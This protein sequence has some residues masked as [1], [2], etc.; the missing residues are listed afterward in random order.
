M[1][2]FKK[3]LANISL[4]AV[5][6]NIISPAFAW[7]IPYT[8]DDNNTSNIFAFSGSSTPN[9]LN[10]SNLDLS[11]SNT[12][13]LRWRWNWNGW[14]IDTWEKWNDK[15]EINSNEAI[16]FNVWTWTTTAWFNIKHDKDNKHN[17][18]NFQFKAFAS[19]FA[20]VNITTSFDS[21]DQAKTK[22]IV[23]SAS[24]FQY[25][26][27][28][29]STDWLN[30]LSDS[31][32]TTWCAWWSTVTS[33]TKKWF[34]LSTYMSWT[35]LNFSQTSLPF[36]WSQNNPIDW[37]IQT[38]AWDKSKV[39]PNEV[40]ALDFGSTTVKSNVYIKDLDSKWTAIWVNVKVFDENLNEITWVTKTITTSTN[41]TAWSLKIDITA[42]QAFRYVT[43][44]PVDSV[45]RFSVYDT[46]DVYDFSCWKMTN[47]FRLQNQNWPLNEP[48]DQVKYF[49]EIWNP[50]NVD[51]T[52]INVTAEIP[53]Q[54]TTLWNIT[55]PAWATN[56][57]DTNTL[58]LSWVNVPVWWTWVITYTVNVATWVSWNI[59]TL[60]NVS[61]SNE[62]VTGWSGVIDFNVW[63]PSITSNITSL[64]INWWDLVAW[65]IVSNTW[66]ITNTWTAEWNDVN[67]TINY[68]SWTTFQT[69]S[70]NFSEASL[71]GTIRWSSIISST[72]VINDINKTITFTIKDLPVN[73][74][75]IIN[76]NTI[77]SGTWTLV[78][79]MDLNMEW[80][81]TQ[82]GSSSPINITSTNSNP[83]A[84]NDNV[85][86]PEDTA[87]NIDILANDTDINNDV[88][89]INS[90]TWATNWTAQIS[91]TWILFTPNINFSWTWSFSYSISDW[92]GGSWSAIAYIQVNPV[93]DNPV[94]NNDNAITQVN[95]EVNINVL[96]N[97]TDI[98]NNS[99][100][101]ETISN[102]VNWT[103]QISG[104]WIIFTPSLNF[105]WTWSFSY[106]ISDGNGWN[107][108]A[109]VEV[110]I[111]NSPNINIST[112]S[113]DDVINMFEHNENLTIT[114]TTLNVEDG[115]VVSITL[116]GNTYT[117]SVTLWKYSI[118]IPSWD[119]FSLINNNTYVVS[120]NVANNL[121]ISATEFTRNIN[122]KLTAPTVKI[123]S[124]LS[125]DIMISDN[126]SGTW[127]NILD[128]VYLTWTTN[129]WDIFN[130]NTSVTST[131]SWKCNLWIW[132]SHDW[133]IIQII[134][135]EFDIY[136][137]YSDDNTYWITLKL[138]PPPINN[139]NFNINS[140]IK[141]WTWNILNLES[142][143]I[144][145]GTFI[146]VYNDNMNPNP[147]TY[148]CTWNWDVTI[149]LHMNAW[150]EWSVQEFKVKRRDNFWNVVEWD[151]KSVW[152]DDLDG[153]SKEIENAWPNLW[154]W[155]WDWILDSLQTNVSSL[156][157]TKTSTYNSLS[158]TWS[159]CR[160]ISKFEHVLEN[161]LSTQDP[162]N[163][164]Y[165][166]W[167]W[168]INIECIN[169]WDT[170]SI[171]VYLDDL[172]DTSGWI[173]R[174][175]NEVTNVYTDISNIINYTTE[176]VWTK[177]V[178]VINYQITDWWPLDDD[179][180]ANRFIKDPA[181]PTIISSPSSSS[182]SS[183]SSSSSSSSTWWGS[184][185]WGISILIPSKIIEHT[186]QEKKIE[187]N[188]IKEKSENI[189]IKNLKQTFETM[190]S[191]FLK[192]N[193]ENNKDENIYAWEKWLS[194]LNKLPKILPK[195]WSEISKKVKILNKEKIETKL[196]D[197]IKSDW[198]IQNQELSYWLNKLPYE[199]DKNE[200]EYIV[201]PSIWMVMPIKN[202][203]NTSSDYN[204]LINWNEIEFNKYLKNWAMKYPWTS[205]NSYWELWNTVI[206]WHS[207]YFKKDDGRYKTAFQSI[208]WLDENDEILIYK[209]DKTTGIYKIFKYSVE[210][211][212]NTKPTDTSVLQATDWKNLT[213]FTC[214][215][216]W[217]IE[218]RW[219]V[220]AKYV[221]VTKDEK[222]ISLNTKRL[223][224]KIVNK[225]SKLAENN[226]KQ[227]IIYLYNIL[228]GNSEKKLNFKSEN[229]LDYIKNELLINYFN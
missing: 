98:E 7:E 86:T 5:C 54:F 10:W 128:T 51:L 120:A 159:N 97:D 182:G 161:N 223:S 106:T 168:N 212:Y 150:L 95:W 33:L 79:S 170:A 173:Y 217:W 57:S 137:N 158:L 46:I 172:Y 1:I 22:V 187:L 179:W 193:L 34:P 25:V 201:L 27:M 213:L 131:W 186:I 69:W 136:W 126:I 198:V 140:Q 146:D 17:Y 165:P 94:A 26:V 205:S 11:K 196:P 21:H 109:N 84:N 163:R 37:W 180:V 68:S 36:W 92:N 70:L 220:K 164:K 117:W 23:K 228:L 114:W 139:T 141:L 202:A 145:A 2:N 76:F 156:V 82:S 65:D 129:F 211:S 171:S 162:L 13:L 210:K 24:Q 43:L 135:R 113:N 38:T 215:P 80:W 149:P 108:T 169:P 19:N 87:I 142:N 35:Y 138:T 103:A 167:L 111:T 9:Y 194:L 61:N 184:S 29:W 6:F 101:I 166:L 44:N 71:D 218:W 125:W 199:Q 134:A 214:T 105:V 77:V 148:A 203:E 31:S 89:S 14:W 178:T 4:I 154:D 209:K 93:N 121:N 64:D 15:L 195:T 132:N 83:I 49:I 119:I 118:N 227:T 133:K 62:W 144:W 42:P 66:T 20:P 99:L 88:L 192:F 110:T 47:D 222:V 67:V 185:W 122:I 176:T 115:N 200:N 152:L 153:I 174:K 50:W 188:N 160:Y 39:D 85:S 197:W 48:N 104:S 112:I 229:D 102:E 189:F 225:I 16:W 226:R 53:S 100:S 96:T 183:S 3:T 40:F 181:W 45:N 190:K 124:P 58:S 204:K 12:N 216:I 130:C 18:E 78:N 74:P 224:N 55:L 56:N 91:W 206:F 143:C 127:S 155:N 41:P 52:W 8:F 157:N 116:N 72:I 207:S 208:I 81:F 28:I 60:I 30:I 147:T 221:E 63:T 151:T 32:I 175:Y 177:Q 107:A 123:L 90:V 75:E 219:I 191:D 73:I 59:P